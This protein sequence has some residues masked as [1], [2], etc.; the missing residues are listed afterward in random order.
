MECVSYVRVSTQRQGASGLGLSAQRSA[1]QQFCKQHGMTLVHEF[2]EVES[3]RKNDRAVLRE[4][5][6][7]AKRAKA[8][9]LIAKLDRLA[10]NVAFIA[11]LMESGVEFRACD[12]P[13]ANR[14]LLHIMAAV[15]EAEAKAISERTRAAL[16]AGKAAGKK[17]GAQNPRSRNLTPVAM[18]M[19]RKRGAEATAERARE[20][21]AEVTPKVLSMRARGLTLA[22]IADELNSQGFRTQNGAHFSAVHVKRLLERAH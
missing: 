17:Y 2:R 7:Y 19:G 5:L 8:T 4:A 10:R 6:A 21:Y 13:E 22:A 20:F 3:G 15:A 14:L 16:R 11:N 12:V 9:L 18:R 1:V